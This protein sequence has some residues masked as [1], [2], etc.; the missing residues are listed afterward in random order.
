M[1]FKKTLLASLLFFSVLF[2][3]ETYE[4]KKIS[5]IDIQF[6]R[7]DPSFSP[8]PSSILK[9]IKS[10][11]G[12]RFSQ[13]VF[14]SDLKKLS[15]EYDRVEP[16]ISI[17]NDEIHI[18]L[19]LW[20]K[21]LIHEIH[22]YGNE[23]FTTKSLQKE[24]GIKP[25]TLFNRQEFNKNFNKLKELYVKKGYFESQLTYTT[26]PIENSNQINIEIDIDEG[27]SGKIKKIVFQGF[28][29]SERSDLIDKIYTRQ[30]NFLTS[31]L[32]GVGI[33]REEVLDQDRMTIVSYLHNRGYA[34][35]KVDIAALDDPETDKIIISITAHRGPLYRFGKIDFNGNTLLTDED[36]ER[37]LLIKEGDPYS[38]DKLRETAQAIKEAYGQKGYIDSNVQYETTL[39]A[40]EPLFNV[41][42]YIQEG[43]QFK[44]GLIRVVGN[45][46]THANVILRESL[47]VPGELF[48]SRKLKATQIRLENV[49]YFKSVN[50]YA[51]KSNEDI[52]LGESYRDVYV[53]VEEMPTGNISMFLGFS[54]TDD[55]FGGL[56]LTE[57]N[58]N[59]R[60]IGD[61][62]SKGISSLRGGGE[63]LHARVS[64]GKKQTNYLLSWM[65]PYVRDSLWRLGFEISKTTSTLQSSDYDIDTYG[66]SVFAAYPLT[67]YWTFGTKYRLRYTDADIARDAGAEARAMDN[68]G[69]LA[70]IGLSM[71]YD[72]TDNA[73][74]AH[75]GIR[76]AIEGEYVG[77]GGK[78]IF[79]KLG[80]VNSVYIPLW[81]KGTLKGRADVRF[82]QP[83]FGNQDHRVPLSERFFLGGVGTV[84]GYKPFKLGPKDPTSGDPLGGISSGLFSVEYSQEIFK[85]M[86]LF[87]FFDAGLIS[88]KKFTMSLDKFQ[89]SVGVGAR[90]ELM[91][92][93]PIILG[94]GY[95]FN[96]K[97][98]E[99]ETFFFSMGGQF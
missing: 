8:D 35:A 82:I 90:L 53:E 99:K 54:S 87:A 5:G 36:I 73:Y 4:G 71:A 1:N 31:W 44:I 67:S 55:I 68:S 86:D 65:D 61:K 95:P 49:G 50:V 24:L 19:R 64:L 25:N 93:T 56:E 30:Y 69:I 22:W 85:L 76:S 38:P 3:Y 29:R 80:Y 40:H 88:R 91:N 75:R 45:T 20:P 74:K 46:S 2:G 16:Q 52:G 6:E 83:L 12:E 32:T 78:F 77:L 84:R 96:A 58:F 14:D 23:K 17:A 37:R 43:S 97:K 92:R 48:D 26:I 9:R 72:S 15:E 47:L 39:S 57:R 28:T 13:L 59:I 79:V 7:Y 66:F 60:G 27:R 41:N 98:G 94:Y 70:G 33:L 18:T 21:P 42:Y 10:H 34:D 63:Y 89:A 81:A 51:V 11:Q 62:F